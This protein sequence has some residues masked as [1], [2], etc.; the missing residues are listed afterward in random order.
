MPQNTKEVNPTSNK[1]FANEH[2][3]CG[4]VGGTLNGVETDENGNIG[5]DPAKFVAG[6]LA[7]A[8]GV[9]GIKRAN[10]FLKDNP[11]FKETFKNEL[12][13]TL[14]SGWE[15]SKAKNPL[16]KTLE[17][18]KYIIPNEKRVNANDVINAA[19]KIAGKE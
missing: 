12:S 1:V 3:G 19:E 18:N 9:A 8:G 17:T 6:F 10:K 2:I 15:N 11:Q 4:L 7:G 14:S 5:F 13:K 16:L